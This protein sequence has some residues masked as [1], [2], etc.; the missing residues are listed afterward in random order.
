MKMSSLV[1]TLFLLLLSC[2][3]PQKEVDLYRSE[4]LRLERLE[5]KEIE[6]R[7]ELIE[8]KKEIEE[9]YEIE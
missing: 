8:V 6:K 7:N 9:K 4:Q 3:R 1:A 2:E 5:Q